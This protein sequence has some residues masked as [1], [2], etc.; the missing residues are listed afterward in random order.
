M[1]QKSSNTDGNRG[2]ATGVFIIAAQV[3]LVLLV[4]LLTVAI[5]AGWIELP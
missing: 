5:A 2:C 4:G 3:L 1:F